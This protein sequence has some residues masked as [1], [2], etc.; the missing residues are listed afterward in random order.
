MKHLTAFQKSNTSKISTPKSFFI[1]Q[2]KKITKELSSAQDSQIES[3]QMTPNTLF[4]GKKSQRLVRVI[5]VKLILTVDED[6]NP[7]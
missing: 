3:S 6:K 1:T 7:F 5:H 2:K 4:K